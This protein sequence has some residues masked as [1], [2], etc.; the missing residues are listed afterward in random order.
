MRYLQGQLKQQQRR[1]CRV[2]GSRALR[3]GMSPCP[4]AAH[5]QRRPSKVNG[6]RPAGLCRF[7]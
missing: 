1:V 5:T 4:M 3:M 7:S 6:R 2:L